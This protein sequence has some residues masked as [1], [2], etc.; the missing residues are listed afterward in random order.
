MIGFFRAI[1][2]TV[3]GVGR[4]EDITVTPLNIV[5]FAFGVLTVFLGAITALLLLASLFI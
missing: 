4:I 5:L 1:L 3:I 2:K